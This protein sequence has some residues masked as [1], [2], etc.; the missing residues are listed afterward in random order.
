MRRLSGNK[1][2]STVSS[3]GSWE[4]DERIPEEDLEDDVKH[5]PLHDQII[6]EADASAS[7]NSCSDTRASVVS[8]SPHQRHSS[9]LSPEGQGNPGV[10]S[11][12]PSPPVSANN[13]KRQEDSSSSQ[14]GPD[15][16]MPLL[17]FSQHSHNPA[18][19][20]PVPILLQ[21]S[22]GPAPLPRTSRIGEDASACLAQRGSGGLLR[23]Q[24]RV[25]DGYAEMGG[26]QMLQPP[27]LHSQHCRHQHSSGHQ[28]SIQGICMGDQ[29]HVGFIKY[30]D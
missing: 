21:Q 28:V 15:S 5:E 24:Q 19:I 14:N 10:R 4:M 12:S 1:R 7:L 23:R 2:H 16:S 20:H 6:C 8:S 17:S 18:L 29:N 22:S 30:Y 27:N 11:S 26:S 9:S 25:D 3:V 13:K